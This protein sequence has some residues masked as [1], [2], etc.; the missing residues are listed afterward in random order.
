LSFEKWIYRNGRSVR[1]DNL[2]IF[3]VMSSNLDATYCRHSYGCQLC[4]S[5]HRRVP[6]FVRENER[7]LSRSFNFTL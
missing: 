3:E 6:L 1:D 7:G 2:S 4:S 5:S